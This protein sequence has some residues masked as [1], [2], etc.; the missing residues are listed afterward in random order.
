MAN[1]TQIRGV[2]SYL[3]RLTHTSGAFRFKFVNVDVFKKIKNQQSYPEIHYD[4]EI[5]SKQSDIPYLW[6]FFHCK[7]THIVQDGCEMVGLDWKDFF[8]KVK[9][10]YYNGEEISR[11]G[12][13][14]PQSFIKKV[15]KDIVENTPK[16]I[17]THFFCEG[18]RKELK[19]TLFNFLESLNI[20]FFKVS[21]MMSY[22]FIVPIL[23]M[24]F[25]MVK[26]N[27]INVSD[28]KEVA[29]RIAGS[30]VVSL[31]GIVVRDLVSKLIKRFRD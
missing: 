14:I 2:I 13:D 25:N 4:L 23:L 30:G 5:T 3:I 1:N 12:G 19:E 26:S 7:S 9:D 15:S 11:Y 24:I 21:K 18:E 29:L 17:S 6:D 22:A 31:S 27:Q 10:I 28:A 20:T 8:Y 16:Q